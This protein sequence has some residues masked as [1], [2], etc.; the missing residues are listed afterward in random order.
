[1][2]TPRMY[3][4]HQF[5]ALSQKMAP[6]EE[7]LAEVR[8]LSYSEKKY[9]TRVYNNVRQ[10]NRT[11]QSIT[12]VHNVRR[13]HGNHSTPG[14]EPMAA[15]PLGS[16][17]TFSGCADAAPARVASAKHLI[18][19]KIRL[20]LNKISDSNKSEM[21]DVLYT[22]Y[23]E[24]A[25]PALLGERVEFI[26][27]C[28]TRLNLITSV[29]IDML[30]YII[31][32]RPVAATLIKDVMLADYVNIQTYVDKFATDQLGAV[33]TLRNTICI[34]QHVHYKIDGPARRGFTTSLIDIIDQVIDINTMW[35]HNLLVKTLVRYHTASGVG[36]R[37]VTEYDFLR[38]RLID[39]QSLA[40]AHSSRIF[41]MYMDLVEHVA[42]AS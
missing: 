29:Y 17:R 28:L 19:D 23:F 30:D 4:P 16:N 21:V 26:V 9:F 2:S 11:K 34:L 14:T 24:H 27:V 15:P 33:R 13:V 22:N 18:E 5:I 35:V 40:R 7:H 1:M 6:M 42:V 32:K 38:P 36:L 12:K 41:I 10:Y 31:D 37:G 3:L 39:A 25:T 20:I 8:Y